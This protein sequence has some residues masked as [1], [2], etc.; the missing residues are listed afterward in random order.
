[1]GQLGL[2]GAQQTLAGADLMRQ[3]GL[4]QGQLA[5]QE[6]GIATQVG[7]GLGALANQYGQLGLGQA[8]VGQLGANLMGQDVQRLAG[9]D[10]Y[11]TGQAQTQ[12]DITFQNQM[13]QYQQP[14]AQAGFL[15]DI[16]RGFPTAQ[17]QTAA[18]ATP[19]AGFGTQLAGAGIT[20]LGL[21]GFGGF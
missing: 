2:S 6:A 21:G 13:R 20:A 7:Q 14:T 1:M 5:A 19:Q 17:I 4:S 12:A 18:T 11:L 8:Q 16:A 9:L 3:L 15:S 10:Q